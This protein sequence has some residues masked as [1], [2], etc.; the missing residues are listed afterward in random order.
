MIDWL[1]PYL[2]Y[3]PYLMGGLMGFALLLLLVAWYN[4]RRG[5]TADVWRVRHN[6]GKR[7]GRLL[8]VSLALLATTTLI[9]GFSA[10]AIFSFGWQQ[11]FFP[12]HNPYGVR[13]VAISYLPT[14]TRNDAGL[15]PLL[16]DLE[17]AP[18]ATRAPSPP[19]AAIDIIAVDSAISAEGAPLNPRRTFT[20]DVQAL[21]F[22]ITYH[23]MAD[24]ALWAY[25]IHQ[26][27]Q[28]MWARAA[29]W[30]LGDAGT[31]HFT[32]RRAEGFPPGAYEIWVFA[33]E[34]VVE[35][36]TFRVRA[37]R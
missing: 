37:P 3:Y 8:F 21:H 10:V 9:S 14:P 36:H 28:L 34:R 25:T 5:Y 26:D 12:P 1:T 13:G 15:M 20:P 30:Q 22:F 7:G 17:I 6:S 11:A 35:Q 2:P 32:F 24:G 18:P 27:G 31:G 33:G 16:D 23:N 4:V 29:L 19:D